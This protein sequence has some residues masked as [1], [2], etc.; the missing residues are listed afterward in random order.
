M[1]DKPLSDLVRQGWEV[2]QYSASI[3]DMGVL[4]H[5]VLVRRKGEHKIVRVRSKML[6]KGAVVEELD[7]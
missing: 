5:C 2:V 7:V 3:G 1:S 6:G 4:E